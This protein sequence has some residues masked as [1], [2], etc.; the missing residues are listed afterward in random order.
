MLILFV[1]AN[2]KKILILFSC[3]TS[4]W[5]AKNYRISSSKTHQHTAAKTKKTIIIIPWLLCCLPLLTTLAYSIKYS[6]LFYVLTRGEKL[7]RVFHHRYIFI[8]IKKNRKKKFVHKTN[9]KNEKDCVF[10]TF[11]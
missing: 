5:W 2:Q 11:A 7:G 6:A 3:C 4:E 10:D 1:F 8:H 9:R